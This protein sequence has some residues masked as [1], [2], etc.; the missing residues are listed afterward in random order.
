MTLIEIELQK[1]KTEVILLWQ[2]VINQLVNSKTALVNFDKNL[3]REVVQTEKWV[4]KYE[5]RIDRDC[6]NIFALHSP[7]AV[8]LRYLLAIL[9][10]NNNLERI[11]DIA[12][13]LA[14]FVISSDK[15]VDAEILE[16][17]DVLKMYDEGIKMVEDTLN[18][19]ENED[20]ALVRT[21]FKMDKVIDMVNQNAHNIVVDYILKH[22]EKTSETLYILSSIRKL[23]RVGD[24]TK[25]I[26]EEIIFY[27]E[28]KVLRHK[29][30]KKR[31][32]KEKE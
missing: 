18:A 12:K 6:E 3:A 26:A 29:K 5:L 27:V 1:L 19:F 11:G 8:D 14:K 31:E 4:N 21:I 25:N 24:Q 28:A 9:K 7:V 22:P 10:I 15:Q 13:G 16:V 23:E 32:L 17:T 2:T 20:S 30:K